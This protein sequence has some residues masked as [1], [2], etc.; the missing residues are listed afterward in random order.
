MIFFDLETR[1]LANVSDYINDPT[2][3]GNYKD[4][5][6]IEAWIA[7]KKRDL[8]ERA[9]LDP[10]YGQII[11]LGI[12]EDNKEAQA[13]LSSEYEEAAII[14]LFWERFAAHKGFVCGYNILS[15]DLPYLLRRSM[16]LGVKPTVK[17]FLA[18]YRTAPTLDLMGALYNWG[19]AKSLKWVAKRYG[20]ENPLPDLDGSMVADMDN[21][22]LKAYSL[23]DVNIIYQ[24]YKLM[25]G[26]YF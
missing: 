23:N 21:E 2:P 12:K 9:A 15:F 10:D 18:K 26:V 20:I 5:A 13:F 3:P 16:E 7:E 8:I 6:K 14:S 25:E 24:L 22:T 1:A 11:A 4:P 19:Q 17:P